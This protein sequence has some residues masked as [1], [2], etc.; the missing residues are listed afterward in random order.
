[1]YSPFT[2]T[3]DDPIDEDQLSIDSVSTNATADNLP[4]PGRLLGRTYGF[5]GAHL[6]RQAGRL[7]VKLRRPKRRADSEARV[8]LPLIRYSETQ[9]EA[10]TGEADD[11][12]VLSISTNAT[13]DNL[14]GPGRTLGLLYGFAGAAFESRAGTVAAALGFGPSATALRITKVVVHHAK[15]EDTPTLDPEQRKAIEKRCR[16]MLGYVQSNVAMTRRQALDRIVELAVK[17]PYVRELLNVL[18]APQAVH[19]VYRDVALWADS[20]TT[21]LTSSRKALICLG[22]TEVNT[23]AKNISSKPLDQVGILGQYLCDPDRSFLALRHILQLVSTIG[24]LITSE[25][26]KTLVS[27]MDESPDNL[28]WESVDRILSSLLS[29]SYHKYISRSLSPWFMDVLRIDIWAKILRFADKLPRLLSSVIFEKF[30]NFDESPPNETEENIWHAHLTFFLL[31][32]IYFASGAQGDLFSPRPI[33]KEMRVKYPHPGLLSLFR[34]LESEPDVLLCQF[35]VEISDP[36]ATSP[37]ALD[38]V[39]PDHRIDFFCEMMV[40]YAAS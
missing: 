3:N 28:E 8:P 26:L 13:A 20:D 30:S 11:A 14:P 9:A 7:A 24:F 37:N 35:Y 5:L 21:L 38:S 29:E 12:S 1:M 15:F 2:F 23:V 16:R 18:G 17:D 39:P 33:V 6:E 22:D 10:G 40:E 19:Q 4:G 25:L 27:A 32:S 34:R 31:S 36:F